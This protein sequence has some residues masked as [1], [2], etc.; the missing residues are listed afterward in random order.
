M[1]L[2]NNNNFAKFFFKNFKN[3]TQWQAARAGSTKAMP[4]N[5][6]RNTKRKK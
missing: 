6:Q 5:I 2:K 3:S 1:R 4:E